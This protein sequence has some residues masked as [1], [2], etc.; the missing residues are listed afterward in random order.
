MFLWETIKLKYYFQ[1][2]Y[3]PLFPKSIFKVIIIYKKLDKILKPINIQS[4]FIKDKHFLTLWNISSKTESR[5]NKIKYPEAIK[6]KIAKFGKRALLAAC[7][8]Q[9]SNKKFLRYRILTYI[10][11]RLMFSDKY[12]FRYIY[13]SFVGISF[14]KNS[15][16]VRRY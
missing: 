11:Q 14:P 13:L 7:C 10:Y 3:S 15:K 16:I 1:N 8:T 6:I 2:I 5:K 4:K 9:S 12:S